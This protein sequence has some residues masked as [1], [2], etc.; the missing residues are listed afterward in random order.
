VARGFVHRCGRCGATG[1]GDGW[2]HLRERCP[3]CGYLFVR[4]PGAFTGVMLVNFVFTLGL[5][6][7]ALIAYVAW[8]G[9]TGE[10][11]SMAPF[12]VVCL[13]LAVVVPILAYP[14]A[15]S[16]WA[17]ID[18]AMRPLDADEELDALAH[19]ADPDA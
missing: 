7:V 2:F 3:R 1:I 17:A 6:F 14:L 10:E 5:M 15:G 16:S 9:V 18:L 8:R 19:A 11:V 13:V 12:G 4:E